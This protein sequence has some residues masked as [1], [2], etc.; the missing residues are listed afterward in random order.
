MHVSTDLSYN[1]HKIQ[2]CVQC[3]LFPLTRVI[4]IDVTSNQ[5]YPGRFCFTRVSQV[6]I[7]PLSSPRLLTAQVVRTCVSLHHATMVTQ[8]D[9]PFHQ[10]F[11]VEVPSHHG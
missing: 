7:F 8:V 10:G 6:Q 9:V 2:P 5:G 4:Q 3:S 1:P 11:K